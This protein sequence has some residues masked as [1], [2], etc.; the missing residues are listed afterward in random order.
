M[1][2]NK[3]Y[4]NLVK[5]RDEN[6]PKGVEFAWCDVDGNNVRWTDLVDTVALLIDF[7][8]PTP[9]EYEQNESE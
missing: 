4:E 8:E 6:V 5:A 2:V 3:L 7:P 9:K 1:N